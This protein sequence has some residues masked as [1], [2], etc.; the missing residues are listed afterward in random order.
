[1]DIK[2]VQESLEKISDLNGHVLYKVKNEDAE[3][4]VLESIVEEQG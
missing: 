2:R 4:T 1:M 3:E